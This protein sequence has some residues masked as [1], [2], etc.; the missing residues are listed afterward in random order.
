MVQSGLVLCF[1]D[2]S[3][4]GDIEHT[5]YV[6]VLLDVLKEESHVVRRGLILQ[7]VVESPL[8]GAAGLVL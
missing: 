2:R 1:G 4:L 7:H 8:T 6:G 3:S 5:D